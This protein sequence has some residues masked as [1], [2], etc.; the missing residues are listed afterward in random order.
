M[1]YNKHNTTKRLKCA[2]LILG[3]IV[4]INS[5]RVQNKV[6]HKIMF[7][8][9]PPINFQKITFKTFVNDSSSQNC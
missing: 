8:K 2:S 3:K 6:G 1:R 5:K 9:M 7:I 4:N